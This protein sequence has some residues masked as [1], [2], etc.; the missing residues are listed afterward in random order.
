MRSCPSTPI[1]PVPWRTPAGCGTA[2]ETPRGPCSSTRP[3]ASSASTPWGPSTI[4]SPSAPSTWPPCTAAPVTSP[5]PAPDDRALQGPRAYEC[6]ELADSPDTEQL[7]FL[8]HTAKHDS[9]ASIFHCALS[10]VREGRSDP[11]LIAA[12]AEW[13]INGKAVSHEVL[14][15]ESRRCDPQNAELVKKLVRVRTGLAQLTANPPDAKEAE[16]RRGSSPGVS[17]AQD[18]GTRARDVLASAPAGTAGR[19]A[20]RAGS[21]R[22]RSC[23]GIP[24]D[25]VLIE[26]ARY[27][28]WNFQSKK[29]DPWEGEHYAP[30]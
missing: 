10:L 27:R 23:A 19:P 9:H 14:R 26:I 5:R 17:A 13:V 2:R 1:T 18:R 28:V 7:G 24:P 6:R 4:A 11:A 22:T 3:P 15:A 29:R 30:A 16:G 25:A 12:S 20:G 8:L 21:R